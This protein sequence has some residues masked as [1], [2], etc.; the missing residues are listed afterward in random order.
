MLVFRSLIKDQKTL[1]LG[2]AAMLVFQSC[3]RLP[4]TTTL[5]ILRNRKN[6]TFSI[7]GEASHIAVLAEFQYWSGCD[8]VGIEKLRALPPEMDALRDRKANDRSRRQ[9]AVVAF[10]AHGFEPPS[11]LSK[12]VKWLKA[13]T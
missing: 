11:D 13:L 6:E 5:L 4:S 1:T 10:R 8:G 9:A 12:V 3:H 7:E 2:E